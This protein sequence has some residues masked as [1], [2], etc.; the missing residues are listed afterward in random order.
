MLARFHQRRFTWVSNASNFGSQF[1]ATDVGG[2]G[3]LWSRVCFIPSGHC[4]LSFL[5]EGLRILPLE[6]IKASLPIIHGGTV[7][8]ERFRVSHVGFITRR[9]VS[10]L[11]L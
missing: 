7:C 5:L 4:R 1:V 6:G 11:P 10:Q 9:H 2:L 3:P 8:P